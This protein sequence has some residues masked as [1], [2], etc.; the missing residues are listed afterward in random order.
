[1]SE[2]KT[3]LTVQVTKGELQAIRAAAA[4]RGVTMSGL[5]RQLLAGLNVDLER[6]R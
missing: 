2:E 1:M 3:L 5:L 4:S 6:R